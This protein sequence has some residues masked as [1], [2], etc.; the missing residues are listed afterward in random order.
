MSARTSCSSG[1]LIHIAL[2]CEMTWNEGVENNVVIT[3]W[4]SLAEQPTGLVRAEVL[5]QW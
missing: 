4:D 3:A 1:V 2:A 5:P